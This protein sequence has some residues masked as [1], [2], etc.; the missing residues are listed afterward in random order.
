[1]IFAIGMNI[2]KLSHPGKPA[3][4]K[5]FQKGK[6]NITPKKNRTINSVDPI[7]NIVF[8]LL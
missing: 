3:F 8:L 7:P 5:I 2:N 4:V 6:I 1:M